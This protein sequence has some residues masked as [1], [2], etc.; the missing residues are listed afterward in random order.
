VVEV[1]A[2]APQRFSTPHVELL[3]YRGDVDRESA[4]P[5]TNDVVATWLVLTVGNNQILETLCAESHDAV[6]SGPVQFK[7][8]AR[9][10]MLRD[11]DGHLLCLEVSR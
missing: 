7:R 2:L 9:R 10:A 1:T 3:C 6:L 8:G 5:E 4:C 11:P